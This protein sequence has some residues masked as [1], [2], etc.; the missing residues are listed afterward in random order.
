[1][2]TKDP[3]KKAAANRARQRRWRAR[4]GK[5][6]IKQEYEARP[7]K[8]IL[9]PKVKVEKV[10]SMKDLSNRR[11]QA[12]YRANRPP[13][14]EYLQVRLERGDFFFSMCASGPYVLE[15][16]LVMAKHLGRCLHKWEVVHHKNGIKTDNRIENLELSTWGEHS[17]NHGKGYGDGYKK[18]LLEGRSR[19]IQELKQLIEDQTKLIRLLQW[20]VREGHEI[21]NR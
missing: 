2:P 21:Q 6:E 4:H 10:P 12:R 11:R 14:N 1:M 19:Q 7:P 13:G 3:I 5:G 16:R 17:R 15:H 9:Q 8:I 20:Q 18:G